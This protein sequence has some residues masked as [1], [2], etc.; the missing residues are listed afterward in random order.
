MVSSNWKRNVAL[1][2]TGQ[3][4]SLFGSS[5]VHYAVMWHITLKTQSGLMMA[6]IAIAGAMPVFFIS[7]FGGVWADRYNKKHLINISDAIIALVTLVMAV[8]FSFGFD[9]IGLL[10]ICLVIRAL[11]QGVQMPAV[12]ALLPKLVPEE[13]LTR[14]NGINSSIQSLV[15]FASPMLGG[16][17]L[18]IAPIQSLMYID[19]ITAIIGIVLLAFFVKVASDVDETKKKIPARQYYHEINEGLKY[20]GTRSFLRKGLV[21]SGIINI[22]VAPIGMLTPLHVVRNWGDNIWNVFGVLS[23]GAEYRLAAIEVGYS[24]GMIVG[25]LILGIWGGFKNKNNTF[26]LFT[27]LFGVGSIGLGLIGNFWVYLIFI[28]LMGA[29]M[30]IRGACIMAMLQVNTNTAYMGRVLSVL[31]MIAT[32]TYSLGMA[33]W[34]PLSDAAA[35]EWILIGTGAVILLTGFA[36]I[37]SK[38][39][40]QA[41]AVMSSVEDKQES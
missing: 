24:V 19:V 22:M 25:G 11:G 10:L 26:S 8:I 21:L 2:M 7:P 6:L 5:L 23:I 31:L 17:L 16:A 33:L 36:L 34:G 32:V 1:F 15:T 12:N 3:G 37:F 35:I 14:C 30:S 29:F 18:A 39:F 13:H 20:I 41:G 27:L 28:S 4:L 9:L 38:A 40:N